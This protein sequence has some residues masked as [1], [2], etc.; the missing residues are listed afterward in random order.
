MSRYYLYDSATDTVAE[1]AR[2]KD[3]N[4]T[5]RNVAIGGA[6]VAGAS[7]G[8]AAGMRYLPGTAKTYQ[9]AR[10]KGLSVSESLG[11]AGRKARSRV[12]ADM[13]GLQPKKLQQKIRNVSDAVGNKIGKVRNALYAPVLQVA[14]SNRG[15][16][17]N[18]AVSS[19]VKVGKTPRRLTKLGMGVGVLGT[20]ALAGGAAYGGKKLMDRRSR[21]RNSIRNRV[22][23]LL[24]R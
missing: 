16:K 24:G 8:T 22:R 11:F 6:A 7:A 14:P 13:E 10:K 19:L 20:A 17:P 3:K 15:I 4:N 1:F 5:A 18:S 23:A 2:K 9:N 21:K 12:Y